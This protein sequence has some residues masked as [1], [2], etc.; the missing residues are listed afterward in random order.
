MVLK[1]E[2]ALQIKDQLKENPQG[3]SITDIVRVV[4]INR[5][6]AGRY[7]ENLLISGQ[8]E[9]RLRGMAKIYMLSQR[10]PLSAVLSISS[11]LIIQLDSNLRIV[12]AN[13]PFLKLVGTDSKT[14]QGKNIE[15]TAVPLV[16]D[17][18]F[19]AF[20]ENIKEG[21]AGK[22]WSGEIELIIMN[23][24]LFCRIAPTVFDDGRKGVSVLLEDITQNKQARDALQESEERYRK[25]VDIS[26]NAVLLHRGG[27]IFFANPA[28]FR[29][30]G[31]TRPD[32]IIGRNV[33]DFIP[34]GFKEIVRKNIQK[35]LEGHPS[36]R[37]E[38]PMIRIDGTP[39]LIEGRGVGTTIGG[40]PA[41]QVAIRDITE[42]KR[43]EEE[44]RRSEETFRSLVQESTDGIVIADEEGR[45]IV[46]NN[47][48]IHISGISED[49]ALGQLYVD[50]LV[51][52][53]VPE[54]REHD[55]IARIRKILDEGL[56]TGSSSFFCRPLEAEI[57]RRTG[58]RRYIQQTA[59]PIRTA[60]GYRFGSIIRDISE[61]KRAE[62]ALCES[63]EKYRTLVDQANDVICI[64]QDG[65]IKMSNPR[66][67][68][69]W[70]GSIE[71]II[72]KPVLDFIHPDA[73]SEVI[74]R[75]NRRMHSES[76][77]S[78]YE[79]LF[80]RKDGSKSFVEL[81]TGIISYKGKK[82]DLVIVRDIND[83]KK[84]EETL[85]E[86][87][88][89][90]RALLN[91]PTDSVILLDDRG[92]I[93]ALNEIA[94]SR[95]GKRSDE[96]VGVMSY[97]LL[98]KEVAQLRR[99]LMAPVLEKKEMVRF[100]DERNGR[101]YDTVAYPIVN[102]TGDVKKIA[103][104]ARDITEQKNI[105]KQLRKNEQ[106][107]KRLLEQSFDAIA[108]H[109]EGKIVFLNERAA[110]ILGAAKP[111]DLTGRPIF[112]F[113][114]PDSRKDLEDRV[115]K[116]GTAEG[117]AVPVIIEKFIRT[118]GTA[119]TVEV[120]A[121]SFEDNGIP[122]FRVAFREISPPE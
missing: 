44:L 67:P 56:Q 54:R 32:E 62:I 115:R 16:F 106:T 69:F 47:A 4:K 113:I 89:T 72:G 119:V 88:V 31:A 23:I 76:L 38:L 51:S 82:A 112:D 36:P 28:T 81:N 26:P 78:I 48:L 21:I 8:V 107:F 53:I 41:V 98:P 60:K 10:V 96:L 9:M 58:G 68:E 25:L 66:L 80:M 45:V 42:T 111:E 5:N 95:F 101:W 104:I 34:A 39:I 30:L 59:F 110:K 55:R 13:E 40:K 50:L 29:L 108:V 83:R 70:G 1:K 117:M 18:A 99:S 84:A 33:L 114:H 63:E 27:K 109:K 2:I 85:R 118:D 11:E 6:T 64:I 43:A 77:P 116:L 122:A 65:V 61:R 91:A 102:E 86:S 20:V 79:T 17:E 93:L 52:T 22:E 73:R 92:M 75:Y 74:D 12:F 35:D 121:I 105:E 103:I 97:D 49:E 87:E 57:I 15:Y 3:L 37:T 94:S 120:M 7:L 46:W 24:V 19:P 90:A 14:L 100:V 71:E